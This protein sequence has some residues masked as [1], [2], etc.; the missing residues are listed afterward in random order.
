MKGLIITGVLIVVL[1]FSGMYKQH[2]L[3]IAPYESDQDDIGVMSGYN[4]I[5]VLIDEERFVRLDVYNKDK[6]RSNSYSSYD[7]D[8]LFPSAEFV[9]VFEEEE[10]LYALYKDTEEKE[11]IK[12]LVV[13][14]RGN[15]QFAQERK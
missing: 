5:H 11:S 14:T 6:E 15:L 9:E 2:Q 8:Q 12:K 1:V 7:M 13:G 3:Y 4:H 10:R